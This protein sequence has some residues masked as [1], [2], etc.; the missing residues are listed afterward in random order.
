MQN[1]SDSNEL[2]LVWC[3]Y[4]QTHKK[5]KPPFCSSKGWFLHCKSMV[6]VVQKGGFCIA[7]S[8]FLHC[9]KW[10]FV[11]PIINIRGTTTVLVLYE[12]YVAA[13]RSPRNWQTVRSRRGRFIVPAY[14]NVPTKWQSVSNVLADRSQP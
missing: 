1:W 2:Q 10:V 5:Q 11:L 9:K 7:K 6:F 4:S 13:N 12:H 8:G 3:S 14:M